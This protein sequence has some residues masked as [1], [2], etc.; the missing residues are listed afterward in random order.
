M[1]AIDRV[2]VYP[3][4][5]P[6]KQAFTFASGSA[7]AV[8]DGAPHVFVKVTDGDGASGWGEA[9]PVP[10]W[11]DE[12]LSSVVAALRDH[13]VPAVTGRTVTDLHG[14]HRAMRRAV[15]GGAKGPIARAA[16]DIA[17]YD[18]LSKRAGLTLR[19]WLGGARERRAV[20][21][22]YTVT[23]HDAGAAK[24][25][26]EAALA[27]GFHHVNFKAAVDPA[28][29]RA[30][31]EALRAAV[32]H[33][34]VW[35]D[36]NRGYGDAVDGAARA[37]AAFTAAGVDVLEQPL[38]IDAYD[39]MRALR[40]ATE[41]PLAVDES[42]VTVADAFRYASAGLIDFMVLKVTRSAGLLPT[43]QQAAV[44]EA[45]GLPLLLS[46]LTDG[47]VTKLAACQAAAALGYDGPAALNG[48]QFTDESAVFTDKAG[49][50]SGGLITLPDTAGHGA[51]PDTD[52]LANF[53]AEV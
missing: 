53:A 32:P 28:T 29:D 41:L 37:A 44:A 39:A 45:A 6:V 10:G 4:R 30:V 40:D 23:A 9:R 5:L 2:D 50:E 22:S 12:S 36:A 27:A 1:T 21:L 33:G 51:V 38:A 25:Q 35:A 11:S 17:V 26:A 47:L 7:G 14:L 13:V 24:A 48:S 18:L 8:G 42:C 49:V 16:V 52:A 15:G 46:G 3:V 31:A 19:E 34:F 20:R 43:M